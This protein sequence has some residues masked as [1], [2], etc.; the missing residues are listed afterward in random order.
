MSAL[1]F[2]T[3]AAI[4][5]I[6]SPRVV[7][8]TL[9]LILGLRQS[10][11]FVSELSYG[12]FEAGVSIARIQVIGYCNCFMLAF[13]VQMQLHLLLYRG[14]FLVEV[15]LWRH[16]N[17]IHSIFSSLMNSPNIRGK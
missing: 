13:V 16:G 3:F 6:L 11:H 2:V 14:F 8:T 12:L 5:G 4:G 17:S 10:V 7:F 9:T 15:D 1:I